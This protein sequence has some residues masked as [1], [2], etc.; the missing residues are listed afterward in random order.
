MSCKCNTYST[1][2]QSSDLAEYPY[3]GPEACKA[4]GVHCQVLDDD[5]YCDFCGY[6]PD[7]TRKESK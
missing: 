3:D 7:E 1:C 6:A 5:G 4:D 2:D